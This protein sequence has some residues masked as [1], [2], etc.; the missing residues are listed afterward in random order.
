ME[1]QASPSEL[2]LR[3]LSNIEFTDFDIEGDSPGNEKNQ[4]VNYHSVQYWAHK[5]ERNIKFNRWISWII[6]T[7]IGICVGTLGWIFYIVKATIEKK[8]PKYL[9]DKQNFPAYEVLV[10]LLVISIQHVR[11][12]S[13]KIKGKASEL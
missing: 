7:A 8:D 11:L 12:L 6:T 13:V 9:L 2:K 5:Y 10:V 1:K 4:K 3:I